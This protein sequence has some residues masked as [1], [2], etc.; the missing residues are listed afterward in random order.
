M[1]EKAF[2]KGVVISGA[3]VIS[4]TAKHGTGGECSNDIGGLSVTYTEKK[5]FGKNEMSV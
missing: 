3:G 1:L 2:Q 5:F 4:G